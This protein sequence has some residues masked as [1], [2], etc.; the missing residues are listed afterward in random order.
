M[1]V[2]QF[3][4]WTTVPDPPVCG[5]CHDVVGGDTY[6][7]PCR[8]TYHAD[9]ARRFMRTKLISGAQT[10]PCP[11][12][13]APFDRSEFEIPENIEELR[14]EE[15]ER[16][17]TEARAELIAATQRQS[18][19]EIL[20]RARERDAARNVADDDAWAQSPGRRRMRE[21]EQSLVD[22]LQRPHVGAEAR[23]C[24]AVTDCISAPGDE[25][26]LSFD[27][28]RNQPPVGRVDRLLGKWAHIEN[29]FS[30]LPSGRQLVRGVTDPQY[31]HSVEL[32]IKRVTETQWQ[33][34]KAF[35]RSNARS[36]N[37][38]FVLFLDNVKEMAR[39]FDPY[40]T[41]V[42]VS[43]GRYGPYTGN[44]VFDRSWGESENHRVAA[45]R[46]V[47]VLLRAL[48]EQT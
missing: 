31:E 8:H 7:A 32:T 4:P 22:I 36:E 40:R 14:R 26:W 10:T 35:W 34:S 46:A 2:V 29:W 6:E 5:V 23:F 9:C 41:R 37:E 38:A 24:R 27:R 45:K 19:A 18:N 11:I 48:S 13:R 15:R 44:I 33:V 12:C 1:S 39:I 47:Q 25:L 43:A 28:M 3:G 30:L 16:V 42:R 17:A 21:N 20:A